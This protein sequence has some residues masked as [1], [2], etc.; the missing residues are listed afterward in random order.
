MSPDTNNP[1]KCVCNIT[2][3]TFAVK[4]HMRS[5][6]L[7]DHQPLHKT[8]LAYLHLVVLYPQ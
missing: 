3:H 5:S 1:G 6:R 7:E 8:G 4:H 2:Y